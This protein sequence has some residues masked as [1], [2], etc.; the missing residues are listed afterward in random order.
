M[1]FFEKLFICLLC[2]KKGPSILRALRMAT[3]VFSKASSLMLWRNSRCR[4]EFKSFFL[5]LPIKLTNSDF[6]LKNCADLNI[7][8][9]LFQFVNLYC[10]Q[11]TGYFPARFDLLLFPTGLPPFVRVGFLVEITHI[12]LA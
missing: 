2:L 5:F 9:L 1:H 11:N 4:K 8:A 10:H 3:T 12:L 7:F 6:Y